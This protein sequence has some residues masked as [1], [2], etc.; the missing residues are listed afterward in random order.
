MYVITNGKEYLLQKNGFSIV[1][2]VNNAT[3]WKSVSKA[4]NVC[5]T[6]CKRYKELNLKVK[7]ISKEN[8]Y[9]IPARPIELDYDI[10]E[11]VKEISTL[12]KQLESRRLYLI[13]EIHNIELDI[14]DIEHAAEFYNLNAAQGY[15]IYKMLHDDRI[16][17]R[18]LKQELKSIE[19]FLGTTLKSN[20]IDNL[21]RSI[22]G[23]NNLKYTPRVNKELF[24]V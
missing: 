22:E 8:D 4:N 3:K 19:L 24:G 7:F 21:E 2:D 13:E 10:S 6:L 17:R 11:K 12:V 23:L 9:N 5:S 1:R 18:K 15:K 20:N 14:V 16:N